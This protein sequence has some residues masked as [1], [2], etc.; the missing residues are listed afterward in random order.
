MSSNIFTFPP[1][2]PLP[3]AKGGGL[4]NHSTKRITTSKSFRNRLEISMQCP[5]KED[6]SQDSSFFC[7]IKLNDFVYL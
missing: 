4:P 2:C 6:K 1:L 7:C 5:T 3:L